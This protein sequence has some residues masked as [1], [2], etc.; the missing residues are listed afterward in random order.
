MSKENNNKSKNNQKLGAIIP[1]NSTYSNT[2]SPS[3]NVTTAPCQSNCFDNSISAEK[4]FESHFDYIKE[5]INEC[6]KEIKDLQNEQLNLK[7]LNTEYDKL[8]N[9]IKSSN[10]KILSDISWHWKAILLL[11][12][13]LGGFASHYFFVYLP[14]FHKLDKEL[15]IVKSQIE[16]ETTAQAN[17]PKIS[18]VKLK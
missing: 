15:A 10:D 2:E 17:Q 3:Q 16:K 5:S 1:V 7:L 14:E 13:A 6:R 11:A 18:T 8:S 4:Y 12:A 9:T